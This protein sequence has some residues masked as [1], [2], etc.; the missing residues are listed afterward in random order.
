MAMP[1]KIN[2]KIEYDINK[3]HSNFTKHGVY[4]DLA[5][6]ILQDRNR[7]D[8]L[9]DRFDYGEIRFIAYAQY[10]GRIWVCIYTIRSNIYRII[11][12]R[13]AHDKETEKYLTT[14]RRF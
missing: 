6:Q 2:M 7:L 11:S 13:K 8:V 9:D 4:L 14:P 12:L 10:Q 1:Y 5:E 3:S